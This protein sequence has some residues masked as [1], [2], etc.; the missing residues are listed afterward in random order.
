MP[1]ALAPE[2]ASICE[3]TPQSAE[4]APETLERPTELASAPRKVDGLTLVSEDVPT[5]EDTSRL[6]EGAAE[7]SEVDSTGESTDT[8]REAAASALETLVVCEALAAPT[9]GTALT[10]E[11]PDTA[12]A[13]GRAAP[14]APCTDDEAEMTLEAASLARA[15]NICVRP[16][17]R[18]VLGA[19]DVLGARVG[20]PAAL[21]VVPTLPIRLRLAL[22]ETAA[23]EAT[24]TCGISPLFKASSM[25][26][27]G[28]EAELVAVLVPV[29]PAAPSRTSAT[30]TETGLSRVAAAATPD[31]PALTPLTLRAS[32]A[33]ALVVLTEV[34]RT[35][36]WRVVVATAEAVE[37]VAVVA[38]ALT[39][40]P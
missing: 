35:A 27:E 24:L 40:R 8:R 21:D 36:T 34:P 16:G 3:L 33:A 11:T 18:D 10:D 4:A 5:T 31:T 25:P 12:E 37:A 15:V 23:D 28:S 17:A 7:A 9:D 26:I 22:I 2:D 38:A 30:S 14:A 1:D 19:S 13:A 20:W 6:S 29:A 39:V 32:E